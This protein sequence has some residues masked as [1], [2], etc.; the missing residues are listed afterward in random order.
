MESTYQFSCPSCSALLQAVL[1]QTLTSVQCGEC[2]DVF[3]VQMPTSASSLPSITPAVAPGCGPT[4]NGGFKLEGSG[5]TSSEAVPEILAGGLGDSHNPPVKRQRTDGPDEPERA[6]AA[7]AAAEGAAT[8]SALNEEDSA[9]NLED[10]LQS[11]TNHR[12]RILLM[13]QDEPDNRNLMELRDQLTNAINQLHGTKSMVQR[14]RTGRPP[15]S[16]MGA[17]QP[18]AADGSRAPKGHSSRKNKPQRCSVCGGV[19]HKSRTCS[20]AVTPSAQQ[21]CQ[22]VQWAT[23]TQAGCSPMQPGSEASQMYVAVGGGYMLANGQ[24]TGG[25]RQPSVG[26]AVSQTVNILQ[27]GMVG[28]MVPVATSMPLAPTAPGAHGTPDQA[29][30]TSQS[31]EDGSVSAGAVTGAPDFSVQGGETS[32]ESAAGSFPDRAES[33]NAIATAYPSE[34]MVARPPTVDCPAVD[35]P[36]VLSAVA[37][38]SSRHAQGVSEQRGRGENLDSGD[39]D[40]SADSN[41]DDLGDGDERAQGTQL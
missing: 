37:A 22:P 33:S 31:D 30:T 41:D 9:A 11:C 38:Q 21:M 13:L 32:V 14:A 2:F 18:I 17:A 36:A 20:M 8:A 19:G 6:D 27:P 40:G 3:D 16:A 25:A 24:Q 29:P 34:S 28:Q 1:K 5:T 26:Q 12:D 4:I 39:A 10:S 23:T 35:C 7:V 15:G